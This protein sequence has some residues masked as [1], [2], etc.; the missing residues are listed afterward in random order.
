[1]LSTAPKC[2]SRSALWRG[3]ETGTI[4]LTLRLPAGETVW[5]IGLAHPAPVLCAER[6]GTLEP[7]GCT[8]VVGDVLAVTTRG[9]VGGAVTNCVANETAVGA[10]GK[11]SLLDRVAPLPEAKI[12]ETVGEPAGKPAAVWESEPARGAALALRS[13]LNPPPLFVTVKESNTLNTLAPPPPPVPVSVK[14][15]SCKGPTVGPE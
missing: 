11:T 8:V 6:I 7:P 3:S 15:A 5:P 14:V 4:E 2:G 9:T 13:R 12:G 10:V 1:M